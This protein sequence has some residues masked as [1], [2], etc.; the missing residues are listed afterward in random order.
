M[1]KETWEGP[2]EEPRA[3]S[4]LRWAPRLQGALVVWVSAATPTK[5]ASPQRALH[6][7]G[8]GPP[9]AQGFIRRSIRTAGRALGSAQEGH[10]AW[11]GGEGLVS[12]LRGGGGGGEVSHQ[13]LNA[14]ARGENEEDGG[15]G[16]C[17]RGV[18]L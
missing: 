18:I 16:D 4:V 13:P 8:K 17:G 5:G 7:G 14:R 1:D 2:A 9:L 3:W 12:M 15:E 10:P 11:G 6:T